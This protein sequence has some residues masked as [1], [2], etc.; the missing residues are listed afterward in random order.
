MSDCNSRLVRVS[1]IS[2]AGINHEPIDKTALIK[3]GGPIASDQ[4]MTVK[5][6]YYGTVK[7]E[8]GECEFEV[9]YTPDFNADTYRNQCG[10]LMMLMS[11]GVSYLMTNAQT[12]N[13]IEVKDGDGKVKLTFKGD[14]VVLY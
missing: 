11:D 2:F 14:A 5:G 8:P 1:T 3:M 12:A 7:V 9:P 6:R 4:V 10:D 13:N